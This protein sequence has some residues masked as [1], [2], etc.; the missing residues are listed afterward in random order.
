MTAINRAEARRYL[1]V[2]ETT[3]EVEAAIRKGEELLLAAAVPKGVFRPFPLTRSGSALCFAGTEVVSQSL[4]A[5]LEG[6][7]Q[8]YLLAV[9]LGVGVDR[10]IQR[11]SVT[12]MALAVTVQACA[13]ALLESCCDQYQGQIAVQVSAE[14][15]FLRPRFS[16]GYGDFPL[17]HQSAILS[18]LEADKRIGL[19]V[20]DAHMLIPTKSV[21]TLI[22]LSPQKGSCHT[23][24]CATCG[25]QDCA[26]R[27]ET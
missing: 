12:D 22:G 8:V 6:C 25:K 21:T 4:A 1:G 9:T 24:G 7:Q 3:P 10:L 14:G 13:A 18:A 5:H 11:L 19:A 16:P 20:T 26:F 27:R 17:A 23:S 2:K 15:L